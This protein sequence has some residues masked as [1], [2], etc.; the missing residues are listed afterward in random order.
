MGWIWM[1]PNP[2]LLIDNMSNST[3][4][5]FVSWANGGIAVEQNMAEYAWKH[6]YERGPTIFQLPVS[7]CAWPNEEKPHYVFQP[8]YIRKCMSALVVNLPTGPQ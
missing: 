6:N 5:V 2:M 1:I 3:V 7:G 8:A 4:P